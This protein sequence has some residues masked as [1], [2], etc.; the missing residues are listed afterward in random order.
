[1]EKAKIGEREKEKKELS[2][3]YKAPTMFYYRHSCD[4][5]LNKK[6]EKKFITVLLL[7]PPVQHYFFLI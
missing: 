5:R 2:A 3:F 7:C 6:I 1:M 4:Y